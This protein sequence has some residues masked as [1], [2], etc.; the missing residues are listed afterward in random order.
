MRQLGLTESLEI[1]FEPTETV[2]K[3]PT[4]DRS[5]FRKPTPMLEA[6]FE[7]AG[8]CVVGGDIWLSTNEMAKWMRRREIL[9]SHRAKRSDWEGSA[10]M[11]F[12]NDRLTLFGSSE[13]VP[14]NLT[15]LVWFQEHLEPEVWDY[16]GYEFHKCANLEDYLR[17]RLERD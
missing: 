9:T 6:R 3:L 4:F 12:P 14:E 7:Y 1:V 11:I 13:E 10:P 5:F 16:A 15:Y 8:S 17:W 2:K